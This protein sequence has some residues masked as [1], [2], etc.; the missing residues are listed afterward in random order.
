MSL[1]PLLIQRLRERSTSGGILT[2]A[3]WWLMSKSPMV[4][5]AEKGAYPEV[6]C[7]T[8]DGLDQRALYGPT[9]RMEF[10]GPVGKG[11]LNAHAHDKAVMSR[12]WDV[13]EDA[14][15]FRWAL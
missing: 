14:T 5:T 11:T 4:Q 1:A 2:R 8:E 9:G 3:V 12:L 7:A 6:M 10:V 15:G 13:S